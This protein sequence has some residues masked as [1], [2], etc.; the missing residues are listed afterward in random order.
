MD[1]NSG[2]TIHPEQVPTHS[3]QGLASPMP[4]AHPPSG[5][6]AVI[7]APILKASAGLGCTQGQDSATE[8]QCLLDVGAPLAPPRAM[9]HPGP[10]GPCS[11]PEQ[12][13]L[14]P[15]PGSMVSAPR[16]VVRSHLPHRGGG[17][18][19]PGLHVGHRRGQGSRSRHLHGCLG[20]AAVPSSD[21]Q[22]DGGLMP[23]DGSS[24][25][26]PSCV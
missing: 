26:A 16:Q 14:A 3:S 7:S 1:V 10:S 2:D 13:E 11:V 6:G 21:E 19:S 17:S 18:S 20:C 12:Q 4:S 25:T 24:F 23:V 15:G 5:L 8:Q 22:E 9:P